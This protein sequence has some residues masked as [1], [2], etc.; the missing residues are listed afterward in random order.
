M[1][2]MEEVIA[3]IIRREVTDLSTREIERLARLIANELDPMIDWKDDY[4]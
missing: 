3:A 4:E 2:D 1:S